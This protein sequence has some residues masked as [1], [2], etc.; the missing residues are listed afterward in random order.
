MTV[1]LAEIKHEATSNY[2]VSALF[3]Y[4]CQLIWFD[5]WLAVPYS[6]IPWL[7]QPP[8]PNPYITHLFPMLLLHHPIPCLFLHSITL[9]A[10][11]AHHKCM[12]VIPS[13]VDTKISVWIYAGWNVRDK[14]TLVISYCLELRICC[15]HMQQGTNVVFVSLATMLA[16]WIYSQT[17]KFSD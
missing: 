6:Y 3:A 9:S 12:T 14:S 15:N 17:F 13:S 1:T 4:C 5:V 7:I 10:S 11:D 8:N 16:C 2:K